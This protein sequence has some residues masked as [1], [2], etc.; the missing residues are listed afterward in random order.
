M[1]PGTQSVGVG[2]G[3]PATPRVEP[4][5]TIRISNTVIL[6]IFFILLSFV[7]KLSEWGSL[8]VTG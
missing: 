6:R 4:P 3:P 1:L 2:P 5:E 8:L 7:R